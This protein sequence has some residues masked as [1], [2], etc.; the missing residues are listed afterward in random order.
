MC[1]FHSHCSG[2]YHVHMH[3]VLTFCHF[4]WSIETS[5]PFFFSKI[6]L[7]WVS[8]DVKSQIRFIPLTKKK[9]TYYMC[10]YFCSFF[11]LPDTLRLFLLS[12][13]FCLLKKFPFRRGLLATS[14]FRFSL[15]ENIFPL[16]SWRI[17]LWDTEFVVDSSFFP[18]T[19]K[20]V[21][22]L[23]ASLFQIRNLS[24]KLI[25]FSLIAFKIFL[26]P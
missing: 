8:D 22:L 14:S 11:H 17:V 24:F 1:N 20:T 10:P 7:S 5:F 13:P 2:Y 4:E 23:L 6:S 26:C 12:F 9:T 16:H 18:S 3:I 25:H 15:S 19:F 21:P